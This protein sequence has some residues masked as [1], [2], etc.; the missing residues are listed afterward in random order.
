[1]RLTDFLLARIADDEEVARA[2]FRDSPAHRTRPARAD[3]GRWKVGE[4]GHGECEVDGI[5]ITIYD[6]GGHTAEQAQH[7]ARHDPAR[8]LA[9]CEANRQIVQGHPRC[10]MHDLP[11]DE[12]DVCM[13]CG[14]GSLWP[15]PTLR[16]LALPY[17]DHPDYREKW[18]P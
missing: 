16:A 2:A 4:P 8:V 18:R 9:Q 6:E 10:D 11:G 12:C 17:A 7:I 14:D 13:T 15:C 5:G 3:D 1:M